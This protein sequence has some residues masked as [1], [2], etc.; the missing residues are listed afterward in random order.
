M[1]TLAEDAL[2][3][4]IHRITWRRRVAGM[5][6]A[7]TLGI[8]LGAA[9]GAV[10]ICL[11]WVAGL[12]GS[13]AAIAAHIGP[14]LLAGANGILHAA[15]VF[16]AF[17]GFVGATLGAEVGANSGAS[18]AEILTDRALDGKAPSEAEILALSQSQGQKKGLAGLVNPKVM[19]TSG[20]MFAAFGAMALLAAPSILLAP[21]TMAALGLGKLA[22][23]G[24]TALGSAHFSVAALSAGSAIFGM[25]GATLGINAPRITASLSNFYSRM[26]TGQLFERAAQSGLEIAARV[27]EPIRVPPTQEPALVEPAQEAPTRIFATQEKKPFD[28][29]DIIAQREQTPASPELASGFAR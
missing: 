26:L 4:N 20:L 5:L 22:M 3:T 28:P 13:S 24:T 21:A 19:L 27:P 15:G 8:A 25:F 23:L 2:Y 12:L 6:G 29:K 18:T 11:P 9:I 7:A 17:G 10:A 14:P 16:G 1:A